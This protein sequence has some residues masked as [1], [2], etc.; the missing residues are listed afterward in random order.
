MIGNFEQCLEWLLEHEG[1]FVDHPDDPG[2]MTNKGI[3]ANTYG[4]WLSEVMDVDATLSENTMRNIPDAHVE[5]IYRQEYWNKI[6][7]DKLPSGLD[8]AVFDWAVNSG[9]GR[10]ARALQRIVGVKADGDIGPMTMAAVGKYDAA[11]LIDDMYYRRQSFY[12]RLKT[13][14]TFGNGWT[15]RNDE[16]REQAHS[17]ASQKIL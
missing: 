3:T 17:L 13:F 5:A 14:E 9:P 4:R 8:W 7:G 2:G 11:M 15:R 12:E 1:G 16:T 10:S 6:S